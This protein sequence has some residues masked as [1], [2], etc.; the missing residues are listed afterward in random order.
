VYL[1]KKKKLSRR[2]WKKRALR[3]NEGGKASWLRKK[4]G[5]GKRCPRGREKKKE[6]RK[7]AA[8]PLPEKD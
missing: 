5:E 2:S 7:K 6:A 4:N 8:L 1:K 3:G